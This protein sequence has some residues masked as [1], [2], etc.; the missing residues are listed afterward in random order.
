MTGRP[1]L[2]HFAVPPAGE[3]GRVLV[4]VGEERL[5][6]VH[7]RL[8][9]LAEAMGL[10][11]EERR[12]VGERVVIVPLAGESCP[13]LTIDPE[14]RN[15]VE[16]PALAELRALI[17]RDA[18]PDG[19]SLIWIDPQ[20]RFAGIDAEANNL[21]ATAFVQFIER[22]VRS[23]GNPTVLVAG[24]SSKVSRRAGSVDARG[25]TGL[26]DAFRWH[27]TLCAKGDEVIF[28]V[29]KNNYGAP[30]ADLQLVRGPH[31]ILRKASAAEADAARADA[32]ARAAAQ[33]ES[34]VEKVVAALRTAKAKVGRA[35]DLAPAARIRAGRAR[36]ALAEAVRRGL[37]VRHTKPVSY[38][39]A[40][41]ARTA[42]D[43]PNGS[44]SNSDAIA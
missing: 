5:D 16:A 9:R 43:E 37:V 19:W 18:G 27:A 17:E 7:R 34:D 15:V 31:G 33:F 6:A 30:S 23:P 8:W 12:L 44:R 4:L 14:T 20:S 13:F 1:W 21:M 22:L 39:V 26:T 38:E 10:T 28:S 25:V 2:D 35:D 29:A 3:R 11:P 42:S 32:E 36:A 24:H 40:Q 41:P